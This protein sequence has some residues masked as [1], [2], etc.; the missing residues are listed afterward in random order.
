MLGLKKTTNSLSKKRNSSFSQQRYAENE[1][2]RL[3]S[4]P[5]LSPRR[6]IRFSTLRVPEPTSSQTCLSDSSFE[7]SML[8][9]VQKYVLVDFQT[10]G[11]EASVFSWERGIVSYFG[12]ECGISAICTLSTLHIRSS[13]SLRQSPPD[14]SNSPYHQ[15]SR[16]FLHSGAP[17]KSSLFSQ[18]TS[19][20]I[21]HPRDPF[22]AR[23]ALFDPPHSPW[24]PSSSERCLSL[25]P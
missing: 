1:K 11:C 13:F 24:N 16:W 19:S 23:S 14:S 17:S 8:F 6:S 22:D 3:L 12:F 4:I 25:L 2:R 7:N 15:Q 20:R 18:R 9:Q 10:K 21:F 5:P